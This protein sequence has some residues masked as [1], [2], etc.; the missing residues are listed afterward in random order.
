MLR[1]G[2]R[3]RVGWIIQAL[4]VYKLV[5]YFSSFSL[6]EVYFVFKC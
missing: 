2:R 6:K 1:G 3:D 4:F 5:V